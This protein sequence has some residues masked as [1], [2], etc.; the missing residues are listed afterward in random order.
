MKA[1]H[2]KAEAH[3]RELSLDCWKHTE[4]GNLGR[5]YLDLLE[6]H[7]ALGWKAIEWIDDLLE[8]VT[9]DGTKV[10]V[11]HGSRKVEPTG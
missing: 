6:R 8:V 11:I 3:A 1:D 9:T 10:P 4:A 7:K 2:A 5:A